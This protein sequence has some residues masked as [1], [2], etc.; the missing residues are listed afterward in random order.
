MVLC[1]LLNIFLG[2][3]KKASQVAEQFLL[4]AG[5]GAVVGARLVDVFFYQSPHVWL[6]SP[7][8][9]FYVWEGGLSSHGAAAG[10]LVGLL[11]LT[12]HL[13]RKKLADFTFLTALDLTVIPA[14]LAGSFIR[15]GNFI[16]QEILGKPTD[17]PWGVIFLHPAD[18]GAI[19]ARHPVQLYES[20]AYLALFLLQ[21][22]L[23]KKKHF[24][25]VPG[26]LSGWFLIL[27]FGGR[28]FIEFFKEEQ[29]ALISSGIPFSMGQLLSIP[30][31]LWGLYLLFR[32]KG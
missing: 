18:G 32:R 23:F 2:S 28:F 5:I 1:S 30:L 19:V 6:N 10:V 22:W 29:S 21:L 4:V 8:E 27:C 24:Y 12:K 9:I 31:M 17:L 25:E 3:K 20:A 13:R 11:L 16:N 26:K 14:A 7:M 15:I